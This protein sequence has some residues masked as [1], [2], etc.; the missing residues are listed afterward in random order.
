MPSLIALQF[1][2]WRFTIEKCVEIV[3]RSETHRVAGSYR[4]TADM[5]QHEDV[6]MG[7][8][9][10]V[11]AGFCHEAIQPRSRNVTAFNG[12]QQSGFVDERTTSCVDEDGAR[13]QLRQALGDDPYLGWLEGQLALR[14]QRCG[15]VHA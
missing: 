5:G 10:R 12:S 1:V 15:W 9:C 7:G 14:H 13:G 8:K 4:C 2:F 6:A 11:A 3:E